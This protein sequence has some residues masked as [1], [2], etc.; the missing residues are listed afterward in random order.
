MNR[1]IKNTSLILIA[2]AIYSP[3]LSAQKRDST[4]S[5]E[6]EVTKAYRPTIT[7]AFKINDIPK[8]NEEE[9]RKPA[10]DYSITS[11]P[12]FSTFSVNTLEAAKITGKPKEESGYGLLKFGAGNYKKPY[13][14]LFINNTGSNNTLF[15][16]HLKH[17][18]SGGKIKLAGGD[19]VDAPFSDN[20]ADIYLKHNFD[21][22]NLFFNAAYNRNRFNYYGYPVSK[23]PSQLLEEGQKVNYFGGKQIFSKAGFN[24]KIENKPGSASDLKLGGNAGYS[25]FS[26]FT[27]QKEHDA[28]AEVHFSKE[29]TNFTAF[30]DAGLRYSFADSV[31]KVK[32]N[33]IGDRD[34]FVVNANPSVSLG[35]KTTTVK[36]GGKFYFVF[37]ESVAPLLKFAPDLLVNFV[38]EKGILNFY[39]GADG[40][41][42]MNTYSEISFQNPFVDP[43]H[44]VKNSMQRVRVFGGFNGKLGAKTN[45]KILAEYSSVKN[46]PFFYLQSFVYPVAGSVSGTD[47]ANNHFEV[48]YDD[49]ALTKINVELYHTATEK[50]NFLLTGNYYSYDL[51]K[52]AKAWNLPS[53]DA[54]LGVNYKVDDRLALSA[55]I[56]LIGE[57]KA[58][59]VEYDGFPTTPSSYKSFSHRDNI[60]PMDMVIDLNANATYSISGNLSAFAQLN[61]F[62]FQRYERWLGYPVQSFNLLAG[63]S[64]SF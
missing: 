32:D 26:T 5:Q 18:S 33:K 35:N 6:V 3:D 21:N 43:Q 1:I 4:I 31:L 59:V 53:F 61:N 45:Y 10:F 55:D 30:F 24:L 29:I 28:S 27:N 40:K 22:I 63:I 11:R 58:L 39:A 41:Y 36:I 50:L 42:I 52:Q 9:Y 48:L 44:D 60:Y 34:E 23:I 64:Y 51:K 19:K 13:A 15:E 62:G 49:M 25:Y 56:Y 7:D 46:Q 12:V 20:V 16:F 17:L 54:K 47:I 14:E 38:P 57:R 37:D 2:L 8:I